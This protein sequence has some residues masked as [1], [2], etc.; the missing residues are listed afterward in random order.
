MQNTAKT[1]YSVSTAAV[2]L[3]RGLMYGT[4]TRVATIDR[5]RGSAYRTI[6]VFEADGCTTCCTPHALQ[7]HVNA[8][9]LSFEARR[10][11]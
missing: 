2:T 4:P 3:K 7:A 1:S 8:K 5:Q 6:Q 9:L 11:A 10:G